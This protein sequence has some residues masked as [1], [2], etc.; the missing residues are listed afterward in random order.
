MP[1]VTVIVSVARDLSLPFIL[2]TFSDR[3]V[4]C[5]ARGRIFAAKRAR[6]SPTV[7]AVSVLVR[8]LA[9][10]LV[11]LSD[12]VIVSVGTALTTLLTGSK[13]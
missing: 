6:D 11:R 8:I 7:I 1:P 9:A 5:V 3:V 13:I 4:V 12:N 10:N 2:M